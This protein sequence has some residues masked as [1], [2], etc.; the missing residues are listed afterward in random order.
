MA[1][2]VLRGL[3]K[4][5]PNG[6]EAVCGVDLTVEAGEFLAIVGP[7]G[8]GKS[9]LLRLIA[10]LEA[11]TAGAV[12]I[13]G[14]DVTRLAPRQ[15]DVAMVFQDPALFP[16]LTVSDNLAFGLHT[17]GV[18]RDEARNRVASVA[19]LLG[20][21]AMLDRRPGTLS[22]GQRQRVA[23]GRAVVK[24]PALFLFD[25]PLSGLDAPLR[26]SI[27]GDLIDLHRTLGATI[28]HVTHDQAEALAV[29]DRVA[30]MHDGRIVEVGAPRSLYERPESRFVAQFLGSPPMNV[31]PSRIGQGSAALCLFGDESESRVAFLPRDPRLVSWLATRSDDRVDLGLRPDHLV[32]SPIGEAPGPGIIS[33]QGSSSTAVAEVIRCEFLGHES[34][35]TVA[36]QTPSSCQ[37]KVHS[38]YQRWRGRVRGSISVFAWTRRRGSILIPARSFASRRPRRVLP[39]RARRYSLI[40]EDRALRWPPRTRRVGPTP[41]RDLLRNLTDALERGL[42][43]IVCQVVETRGSTPQKAGALMIVDADGGQAG[44]LGGGCIEAEVKQKAVRRIGE[45]GARIESFVLDHDY[46]WADG[47]ICGGKMVITTEALRGPGPLAYYTAYRTLLESGE[48]L[49]EAVVVDPSRLACNVPPGARFV[50]GPDGQFVAGW[51]V[52]SVPDEVAERI[53]PLVDRPKPAMRGGVV[54]MPTLPRIRLVIV[55]AGHVGQAVGALASQADF[56]VWVV[57]D[58]Q[59]YANPERFPAAER[60]LVGPIEEVLSTLDLTPNTFALIVTRGHGHDQE[61]LYHLATTAAAYVGLIKHAA[62]SS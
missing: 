49:T 16:H 47:L 8:S 54:V 5:F 23:L 41:M 29:S 19:E 37:C 2:V 45:E 58:R 57:D 43:R 42:E 32:V 9:T 21:T 56:D 35:A 48:G 31:L 22:G 7:S 60:L 30:V 50:F 15:R 51:P 28:L 17:R 62:R 33:W 6:V 10:G 44:T 14:R 11:P 27:R 24:R 1:G 13:G 20:L 12:W 38:I 46:A 25:E 39:V 40:S 52:Q 18:E 36:A 26:A 53:A 4:V 34:I 59:Q 55:G 61:A 3:G